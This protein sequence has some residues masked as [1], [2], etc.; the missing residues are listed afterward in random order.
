[1]RTGWLDIMGTPPNKLD[2]RRKPRMTFSETEGF[3]GETTFKNGGKEGKAT[4]T[5]KDDK[6]VSESQMK[7]AQGKD[8][9]SYH[10]RTR[11]R[12]MIVSIMDIPT[13]RLRLHRSQVTE[14]IGGA[15]LVAGIDPGDLSVR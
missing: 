5:I 11:Q 1:M 2:Q 3:A 7:L 4:A 13:L 10:I 14:N 9:W 12:S 6:G 8:Y 15:P